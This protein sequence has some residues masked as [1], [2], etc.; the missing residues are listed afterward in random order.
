[1]LTITIP[2]IELY[3][4]KESKF[5]NLSSTVVTLE[6]S[7]L[8]LSKWEAKFEKPFLGPGEKSSSEILA[9]I[10]C[11]L[12]SPEEKSDCLDGLTEDNFTEINTYINSKQSA[13]TF[14]DLPEHKKV[15]EII[16][17]ELIYFWMISFKV[18][19]SCETWN[20][21]RLF[22]L[23]RICN[24]KQ[25]KPKRISTREQAQKRAELNAK[26]KAALNTTG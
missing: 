6:H 3:D 17:S 14:G 15:S 4:E 18:P 22:S 13:T 21:N 1:M 26:R 11:M 9:Y 10:E 7:L 12:I 24:I 20:L 8:S 25:S 5:I 16:T 19:F 23:I 2:G